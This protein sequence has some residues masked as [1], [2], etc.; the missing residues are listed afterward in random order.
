MFSLWRKKHIWQYAIEGNLNKIIEE[1]NSNGIG[2]IDEEIN[3]NGENCLILATIHN[4]KDIVEKLVSSGANLNSKCKDGFTALM[5]A[6]EDE[7]RLAIAECILSSQ[8]VNINERNSNDET[9]LLLASDNPPATKLLLD[10]GCDS[11]LQ[12]NEGDTALIAA[13]RRNNLQTVSLLLTNAPLST[14]N[15]QNSAGETALMLATPVEFLSIF[16]LL[17]EKGASIHLRTHPDGFSAFLFAA[18]YGNCSAIDK[19]LDLGA[20]IHEVNEYGLS[21]VDLATAFDLAEKTNTVSHLLKRR[22]F[23]QYSLYD[24][25]KKNDYTRVKQLLSSGVKPNSG[26]RGETPLMLAS[27]TGSLYIIK[28]L[29][30][31][32][33]SVNYVP[34]KLNNDDEPENEDGWTPLHYVCASTLI[35]EPI[36]RETI[37]MLI[38][39]GASPEQQDD[40]Q[41]TP[42][43]VCSFTLFTNP[44]VTALSEAIKDHEHSQLKV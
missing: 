27:G 15:H 1:I 7:E 44:R 2:F 41:R 9:A 10:A 13:T 20:D 6:V 12:N 17:L 33:A 30:E 16:N 4:H 26:K 43:D 3:E 31:Y 19:L 32:G 37:R 29:L 14:I 28:L 24:A 5:R 38:A 42:E 11:S 18:G 25:V 35:S 36:A 8:F 39:N 34:W 40:K 22:A 23:P 21:A